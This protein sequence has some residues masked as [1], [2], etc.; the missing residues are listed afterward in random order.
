MYHPKCGNK[1][2]MPPYF[3]LY[4]DGC[5]FGAPWPEQISSKSCLAHFAS[6]PQCPIWS[7]ASWFSNGPMRALK[8]APHMG[9]QPSSTHAPRSKSSKV[10]TCST[11]CSECQ[12]V[13]KYTAMYIGGAFR[14]RGGFS[15]P[16]TAAESASQPDSDCGG[17]SQPAT[18]LRRNQPASQRIY[19][20]AK[21][22]N[23]S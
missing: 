12:L 4:F 16:A 13:R 14:A 10:Y 5:K 11:S 17:I 20:R 9:I 22:F 6:Q 15:Q 2:T 1:S 23:V 19:I 18:V 21:S 7:I 3:R 8:S